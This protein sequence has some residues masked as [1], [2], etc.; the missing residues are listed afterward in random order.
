[1]NLKIKD[2]WADC[3]EYKIFFNT[4][5]T[6]ST[7]LTYHKG[8]KY[9]ID[10]SQ[11]TKNPIASLPDFVKMEKK[12]LQ[13]LM[14]DWLLTQQDK[15]Y[16][17]VMTYLVGIEEF[18]EYNDASYNKK[19]MHRHLPAKARLYGEKAYT[20]EQIQKIL[21]LANHPR[22]RA[23][24]LLLASS[25][26]RRGGVHDLKFK[27]M[28][29]IE[30]CYKF[31]TYND[32]L[33]RYTTFCTP[34]CREAID[35]YIETR[36]S[37][38]EVI[39]PESHVIMPYRKNGNRDVEYITAM[40]NSLVNRTDI[41]QAK[42][43]RYEV[44]TCHGFRKFMYTQL[45]NV[46]IHP[47]AIEKLVGHKDGLKHKYNDPDDLKLFEDYKKAIPYLTILEENRQ[48]QTIE[49]L[50]KKSVGDEVATT[51]K[52]DDMERTIK[53][54]QQKMEDIEQENESKE[55]TV[56]LYENDVKF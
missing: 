48:K 11:T 35:H 54:L 1:M 56:M 12:E 50:R 28:T 7:K 46:E 26:M 2:K 34:E 5:N 18:L 33:Q 49:D 55:R 8:L 19:R 20:L 53:E 39:T 25:G 36:K 52:M 30:D 9:L 32:D 37:K 22:T 41:R 15:S 38:G 44:A 40:I 16:N 6:E 17:T 14:E 3:R 21:S 24:C 13:E 45:N 4:L 10:W 51:K 47:N 42:A 31:K 23:V 29:P 27:D 43:N